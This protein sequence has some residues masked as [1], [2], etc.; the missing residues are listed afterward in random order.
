A[1]LIGR[2]Q[3]VHAQLVEEAKAYLEGVAERLRARS[4]R[5]RTRVVLEEKPGSAIVREAVPSAIDLIAMGTHGRRGLSR[6]FLGR[7][8]DK[9]IRGAAV[10]VLVERPRPPEKTG[11]G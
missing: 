11:K 5:V 1:A 3:A 10:P 8:A 9:V 7:V 2:M 4:V 6:L